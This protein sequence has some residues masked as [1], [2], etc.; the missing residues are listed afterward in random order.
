MLRSAGI[1]AS[2]A[3]LNTWPG[4]ELNIRLPG[5]GMFDHAIVYVPASGADSD[6]WVDATA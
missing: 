2:L 3:L 5:M 6:L 1:L 4:R